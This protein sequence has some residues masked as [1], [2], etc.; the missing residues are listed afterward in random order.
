MTVIRNLACNIT[1]NYEPVKTTSRIIISACLLL[2]AFESPGQ[3]TLNNKTVFPSG[4]SVGYGQGLFS[5]KDEYISKEKYSG[6]LPYINLEWGRFHHKK[7]YHLEFEYRNSTN[8]KNNKISARV[9]QFVFNQDFSYPVGSFPLFS[10]NVYA[11]LGPSVQ[12]FYYDIRY[13]F[14]QPGTFISPKTFGII[15]S[16]AINTELIYPVNYKLRIEGYLRSNVISFSG[17]DY[18]E[19]KYEDEPGPALLTVFT[20]TKFDFDLSMRYYLLKRV[21]TALRYRFDLIRI[22]KWDPYIASGNNLIISL[23]FTF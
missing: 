14:G 10:R 11:Y 22:N 17:K 2:F 15:G 19:R 21:S 23:N 12:F 6:T 20:V 7:A 3:D 8:I 18:D 4:I 9:M 16:L 13:N 5:V 1:K